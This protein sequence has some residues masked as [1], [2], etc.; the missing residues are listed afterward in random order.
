DPAC[1]QAGEGAR[2]D[3]GTTVQYRGRA[4][5]NAASARRQRQRLV[6]IALE[7]AVGE[8]GAHG[9]AVALAQ[10]GRGARAEGAVQGQ[11]RRGQPEQF[12]AHP[13]LAPVVLG[14]DPVREIHA[15]QLPRGEL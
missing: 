4:R 7:A 15:L 10:V 13:V 11:R 8:G 1:A 2:C 12:Q 6:H 14:R 3:G 5:L 9:L